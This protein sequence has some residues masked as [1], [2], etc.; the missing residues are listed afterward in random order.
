MPTKAEAKAVRLGRWFDG[1]GI[2]LDPSCRISGV[3]GAQG[4]SDDLGIFATQP[5][6][7]YILDH[8]P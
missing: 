8:Q 5:L 7:R 4:A 3:L 6:E 2:V 1:V